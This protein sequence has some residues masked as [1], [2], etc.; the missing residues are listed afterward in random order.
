MQLLQ[1]SFMLR[2]PAAASL[3]DVSYQCHAEPQVCQRD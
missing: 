1:M 3:D 2:G